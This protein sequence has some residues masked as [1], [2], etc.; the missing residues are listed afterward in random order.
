MMQLFVWKFDGEEKIRTFSMTRLVMG[1]KPSA[2]LSIIAVR[3]TAELEN[4]S[5]QYPIAF[6]AI[7]EDSYV[8]NVFITAP[9]IDKLSFGIEEIEFVG[10]KGGFRFK[11]WIVS[12]QKVRQQV[13]G[14][15]LPGAVTPDEE[16]ALG[17]HWDVEKDELFIDPDL[18]SGGKKGS[19]KT[20]AHVH[21]DGPFDEGN[22]SFGLPP[23]L[24]LRICLSL[25]ARAFDPLGLVLPT[26]MIGNLLFRNNLQFLK[27]DN[28][29][30]DKK[31][32]AKK[33]L[34]P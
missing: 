24:T 17:V 4:F 15:Q 28:C 27:R 11:E 22:P 23:T 6:K 2:N 10:K 31:K 1:N 14:I 18:T 30:N 8:D 26:R 12:G 21:K 13:I 9:D 16:K 5:E 3:K 20:P 19:V 33:S 29:E 7:V 34:I 32:K 25:H